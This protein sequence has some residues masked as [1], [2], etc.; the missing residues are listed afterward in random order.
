MEV[1]CEDADVIKAKRKLIPVNG[2]IT[3]DNK[4]KL[5]KVEG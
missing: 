2:R 5:L 4:A 3:K 1:L